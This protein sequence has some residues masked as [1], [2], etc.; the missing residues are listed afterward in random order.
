VTPR[1]LRRREYLEHMLEA[2]RLVRSYTEGLGKVDF[3]EDKKTQQAVI[4]NLFVVGEAATR[5]TEC[6]PEL[7][8][9]HPE[10]E[11]KAIRGMRNR[12]AHGYFDVNIDVVWDTVQLAVPELERHVLRILE[13]G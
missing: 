5:L 10:V 7:V 8:V 12:L 4:L 11:W 6:A 9:A 3:L 1:F 13:E 2:L